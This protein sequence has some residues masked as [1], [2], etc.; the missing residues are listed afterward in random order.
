KAWYGTAGAGALLSDARKA[1]K[2]A[3]YDTA[4]YNLDIVAHTSVPGFDWGGLGSVGGKGVWLQAYSVG[5]TCHE[6][7]HNYG[8]SHAN[9]WDASAN[10][11]VIGPG[12]NVEYG[13]IW[14][15]MGSGGGQFNATAKTV[16]G[17]LPDGTVHNITSNGIYRVYAFDVPTRENGRFYTAKV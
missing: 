14:D 12:S 9:Y 8:L 7:G 4:N 2:K 11:S 1:A 13:N 5:V 6:L 17:W 10:N 3:G 15:T 16:L